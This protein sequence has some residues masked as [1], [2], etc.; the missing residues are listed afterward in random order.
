[1]YII[2][3]LRE[4]NVHFTAD[5]MAITELLQLLVCPLCWS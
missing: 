2:V 4:N 3:S 1:M 5:K